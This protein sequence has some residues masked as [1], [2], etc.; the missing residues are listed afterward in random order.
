MRNCSVETDVASQS[1]VTQYFGEW[2]TEPIIRPKLTA[3]VNY[4]IHFYCERQLILLHYR[5]F[6]KQLFIVHQSGQDPNKF[7]RQS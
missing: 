4:L 5:N 3:D 7:F 6:V 1:K 2:Q